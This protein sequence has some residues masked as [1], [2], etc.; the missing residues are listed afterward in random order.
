MK[1][2][3][4]LLFFIV[5]YPP[6]SQSQGQAICWGIFGK[7]EASF[8]E[9]LSESFKDPLAKIIF[10]GHK[11]ALDLRWLPPK[12]LPEFEKGLKAI[13][14]FLDENPDYQTTTVLKKLEVPLEK[15]TKKIPDIIEFSKNTTKDKAPYFQMI[16][17]AAL[18]LFSKHIPTA[19][20][21]DPYLTDW[22][23]I[24]LIL[25]S[26]AEFDTEKPEFSLY[27]IKRTIER[28]YSLKEFIFCRM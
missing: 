19:L 9:S 1:K 8:T 7:E 20:K 27:K 4:C 10:Q 16:A 23:R 5:F 28:R 17:Q 2:T 12:E 26:V 21:E 22:P 25:K 6:S 14:S 24:N 15:A 3:V 13:S 11:T 18:A